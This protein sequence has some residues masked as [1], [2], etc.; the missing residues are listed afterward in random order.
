MT[1]FVIASVAGHAYRIELNRPECGNLVTMDMVSALL[2]AF[3]GVPQD[4]KLVVL[5]GRGADFCMEPRGR[6]DFAA[7]LFATVLS[8]R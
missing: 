4:A 1:D 2:D 5:T 7:S 6:A 3:R 8:S